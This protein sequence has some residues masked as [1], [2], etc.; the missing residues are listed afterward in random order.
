VVVHQVVAAVR[1]RSQ[2]VEEVEEDHRNQALEE[3][4]ALH[5]QTQASLEGEVVVELHHRTQA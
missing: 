5:R 4:A 1:Q 3:V 2:V